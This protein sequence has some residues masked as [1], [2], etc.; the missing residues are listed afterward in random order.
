MNPT[1]LNL[2]AVS[3]F[4]FTLLSLVGPLLNISPGAVAIALSGIAGVF[5]LDRFA[6]KG[7]GGNLLIDLVS[8]QSS[9]Y[10]Q[11]ILHHEAGHFLVAHLLEVPAH[12]YTLSAW[13]AIRA[14]LPGLGGVVLDT[15]A[16]DT[17][18]DTS[19]ESSLDTDLKNSALSSQ[20]L[21]RYYI[22]GMAGIAAETETY[23]T[24]EGGQD[25]QQQLRQLWKKMQR[26]DNTVE[27]Q[28]RWALLQAQ[29][30]LR[31]QEPAYKA[32][33]SAMAV[34]ASVETCQAQIEQHRV[35]TE[36]PVTAKD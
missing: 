27:V 17:A 14:G 8:S 12:S 5:A 19:L 25:D 15:A 31:T 36:S 35:E 16:I 21:N 34:R 1:T 24:A 13:E 6:A 20:Q 33:V 4:A 3:V 30:L 9:D 7:R 23:G 28:L 11:R 32:L 10:R 29:T 26:P 22:I 18:I 2:L